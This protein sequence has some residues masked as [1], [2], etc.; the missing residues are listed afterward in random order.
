MAESADSFEAFVRARGSGLERA[1]AAAYGADLG[2]DAYAEALAVGWE[3]WDEI[4]EMHN[5]LGYLYRVGQSKV[6]PGLRWLQRR[7][8]FA[9]S[10]GAG[11]AHGT[12]AHDAGL[13]HGAG[14]DTTDTTATL[15][16]AADALAALRREQ[17]VAV[18][19]VKAWG[20]TYAETAE[21]LGVSQPAVANHIRRGLAIL[22]H[23]L[24]VNERLEARDAREP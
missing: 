4:A 23:R 14:H 18:L 8:Q 5:P 17:R 13:A 12:S 2:A 15:L 16:D 19:M 1:F 21:V 7:R 20:F 11:V 9:E 3:R 10:F 6:R 22:R 24:G